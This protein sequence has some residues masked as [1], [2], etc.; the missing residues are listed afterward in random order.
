MPGPHERYR[1]CPVCGGSLDLRVRGDAERLV[2]AACGFVFY[3]NPI[4]GVAV[5]VSD[6]AHRVLLVQRARGER[7]GQWCIPCGNVEWDEH[8]R[9]AAVR[10]LREETGLEV[11][12][13]SVYE[14]HSNFHD[15]E[16][17]TVGVWFA[18]HVT[19]GRLEAGDDASAAAYFDL[20]TLPPLAF[21]TDRLVLERM[22]AEQCS[23][24][25]S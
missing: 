25:G 10:E 9:E 19:G 8:I 14:V 3:Q 1:F 13:D 18:G 12:V 15:P 20:G 16:S 24:R 22:W 11:T 21:E 4:V 17:H 6:E 5:I 7:A 2:C 23:R